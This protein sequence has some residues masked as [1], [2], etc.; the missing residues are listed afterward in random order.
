MSVD[1]AVDRVRSNLKEN[2]FDWD[3]TE[4]ELKDNNQALKEL[5]PTE[6]NEA[7]SKLSDDEL[8]HWAD[9]TTGFN[10]PLNADDRRDLLNLFA[11]DLD[12]TQLARVSDAFGATDVASSVASH[13]SPDKKV[14]FI[15]ALQA[16]ADGSAK[17]DF[18]PGFG[19]STSTTTYGNANAHAIAQVLGSLKDS[20]EQ[21]KT[22]VQS[23]EQSGK[24]DDV[25]AAA[26]GQKTTIRTING[27]TGAVPT[28]SFSD[29]NL[30]D[31]L[32]GAAALPATDLSTRTAVFKGAAP[33]L[34]AMQQ[35]TGPLAD[36][37]GGSEA[38]AQRT[39][40]AMGKL[41]T[42]E[43]AESAGIVDK[44]TM[45]SGVTMDQNIA[46]AQKHHSVNPADWLWFYNQVKN[47]AQWDYKQQGAQYQNF[48]NYNFG[49]TA[50]AMGIPENIALRGAGYAQ[51]RAG[52]SDPSWGDPT[53]WN[54]GPYG[55]D[56]A[57]Q[58]QI[59]AGYDYYNSGLWRVWND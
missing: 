45:P 26:A 33:Q 6:R 39:A 37:A 28:S 53:D 55:D 18:S 22:A 36:M 2:F 1:A 9:E 14:D 17:Y 47:G 50:A 27:A 10:S 12:S 40:N 11:A 35:A 29:K 24:M 21:F 57:D 23:L 5:S 49:M 44:Q 13:A 58:A 38:A 4:K 48:G 46:D 3:V 41:L 52:T 30:Q 43:Q 8:K 54:G 59:K 20:P 25:M 51:E 34:A 15:K 7:I 19:S 56:P 16:G 42:R 32:A 31:I